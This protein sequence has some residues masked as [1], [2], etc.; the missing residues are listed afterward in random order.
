MSSS[1]A[2]AVLR[3]LGD[4]AIH[5]GAEIAET[6]G[7]S[8]TLIW[9]AVRMIKRDFSLMVYCI[10]GHGYRLSEPIEWLDVASVRAGFSEEAAQTYLLAFADQIDSTNTH[11]MQRAADGAPHGLVLGCE[12]Q[13]AA[14]GRL[15]RRWQMKLGGNLAFSILWRFN[16]GLGDLS[17]LSL[18]V[19]VAIVRV[20][21]QYTIPAQLK[22]P[23]DVLLNS[24]KL[25][26]ILIELTGDALG[27]VPV[28]IGIG[29]NLV[30]PDEVDQP[31]TGLPQN[32]NLPGRN[33]LLAE[34]LNSLH[35][36]LET[37]RQRSFA[38]LR[39]EW[40]SYCAH[41]NL[42]IT[43]LLPRG[44]VMQGFS[45]GVDNQGALLVDTGEGLQ[46][47]QIGEVSLRTGSVKQ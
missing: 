33:Q 17:G 4:G 3:I 31:V 9:Q 21:R 1:H 15:G 44:E 35:D 16:C 11:L 8:R 40:E 42:P 47:F 36:V 24:K 34:M 26:G 20:L 28:V 19:G 2:F 46:S 32:H 18:A 43:L 6:L 10:R 39:I 14:R 22:W 29:I 30:T 23:N 37:F 41:L 45:R 27:P 13:L 38:A 7:C 5:S 12:W 25:A